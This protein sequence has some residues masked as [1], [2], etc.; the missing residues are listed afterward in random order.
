MFI[1]LI[2]VC[3]FGIIFGVI[4][5]SNDP[6]NQKCSFF[7]MINIVVEIKESEPIGMVIGLLFGVLIEL[8]RQQEIKN[9]PRTKNTLLEN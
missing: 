5:A 2:T 1:V 4:Q 9:R 3:L 6:E 8:I 7:I